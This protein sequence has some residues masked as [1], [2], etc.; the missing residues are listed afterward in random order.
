MVC[1]KWLISW[2]KVFVIVWARFDP[3]CAVTFSQQ[4][5]RSFYPTDCF[6]FFFLNSV[7]SWKC[8]NVEDHL[9]RSALRTIGSLL[10]RV[11]YEHREQLPIMLLPSVHLLVWNTQP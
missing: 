10:P 11:K 2:L 6:F 1:S 3:E 5:R 9:R 4:D 7:F 8:V